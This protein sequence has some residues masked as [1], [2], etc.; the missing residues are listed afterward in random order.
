MIIIKILF[1]RYTIIA[2]GWNSSSQTINDLPWKLV[3]YRSPFSIPLHMC[4]NDL[5]V[6]SNVEAPKLCTYMVNILNY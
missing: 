1:Y 6:C 2:F 5:P 3:A 4:N